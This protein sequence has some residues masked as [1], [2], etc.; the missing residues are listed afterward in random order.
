[1]RQ[2]TTLALALAL[3]A[4][5]ASAQP[6][7]PRPPVAGALPPS[8]VT[9]AMPGSAAADL[10]A[11][12]PRSAH[13]FIDTRLTWTFGDDDVLSAT[14]QR[15]PLSP[16]VRIGDREQYQLFFDALNSRFAGRENLTHLALYARAPG[17]IPRVNT[18]AALVLRVD[19]A[20]LAAGAGAAGQ[21]LYDA[22]TYLRVSYALDP[23]RPTDALALTLFPFDT[24]RFRLGYLWDLSWGGNDIFPRRVGP[25]PGLKL[26]LDLGPF[27]AWAG[28][29]T[30]GIAVPV[31]VLTAA[32][33]TE[34]VRVEESQYA[35]LAGLGLRLGELVRLDLGGGWFS[36]GRLDLA[37]ASGQPAYTFGASARALVSQGLRTTQSLD[38]MLYRNDPTAPFVAFA[39]ETYTPG[40]VAW[41]VSAEA[42]VIA[43]NLADAASPGDAALQPGLAAALQARVRAGYLGASVTALYR[44]APFI[45][46]NVPGFVPFQT[47]P[48]DAAARPEAFVAAQV[49]YAF[50]AAHLVPSVI[51]GV[52]LP[53]ALAAQVT[54]G[55]LSSRRTVVIRR[56]GNFAVL[57]PGD[58]AV[59]IVSARA[60]LR[61]ELST[62]M[63]GIAWAQFVYDG[64]ASLLQVDGGSRQVRVF[65]RPEQLGFGL[66][67]QA[68]F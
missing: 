29:K 31:D 56:A 38:M 20:Q 40:R 64:N 16:A 5:A 27:S 48:A 15:A 67:L 21:S 59:P 8:S 35:G 12:A 18:E 54:E 19:L 55:S 17:F 42:S 39:P 60:S 50:T 14:G 4:P 51:V 36:Q 33:E 9:G 47:L 61:W 26:S 3:A 58:A 62:I 7:P 52:Q 11:D 37:G 13:D 30:A 41:S 23:A 6:A 34:S 32:R 2:A 24:D 25:A 43:Q 45:L 10:S 49:D 65:Q 1:M 22:G 68:R 66:T 28:F 44:D 53:A 63:A 46:R 57:P